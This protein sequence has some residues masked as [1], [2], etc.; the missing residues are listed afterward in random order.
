MPAGQASV[1]QL[2]ARQHGGDLVTAHRLGEEVIHAGRETARPF[3]GLHIGGH[4]HDQA[5]GA[6]VAP[7]QS[8]QASRHGEAIHPRHAQ[9]Q[10]HQHDIVVFRTPVQRRLT[11]LDHRHRIAETAQHGARH[12]TIDV[13]VIH[14]QHLLSTAERQRRVGVGLR[15]A[16]GGKR[17]RQLAPETG[18]FALAGVHA[19]T[20]SHQLHQ[21]AR[22]GQ[23]Q[24]GAAEAPRD[25]GIP[26]GEG[27]EQALGLHL[28]DADTGVIDLETD[29]PRRQ[30]MHHQ[31]DPAVP[32]E[33]EG[34]RQQVEQHLTQANGVSHD[35]AWQLGRAV[36]DEG[37]TGT[38]Q[39][40]QQ[41]IDDAIDGLLEI[42]GSPL[43]G[44]L[45]GLDLR[46]VQHVI[47]Q[48]HQHLPAVT[49]A[50]GIP[51]CA[52]V[53]RLG[54]QQLAHADDTVERRA[55]LMTHGGEEF[56]LGTAGLLGA[57]GFMLEGRGQA[58]Q[59]LAGLLPRTRLQP[60]LATDQQGRQYHQ[61][62]QQ[63]HPMHESIA[64]LA[65]LGG[66]LGKLGSHPQQQRLG[67]VT[68]LVAQRLQPRDR[69]G[70]RQLSALTPLCFL[71]PLPLIAPYAQSDVEVVDL[72]H[73]LIGQH[74]HRGQAHQMMTEV[75]APK[76]EGPAVEQLEILQH[77][78]PCRTTLHA[79]RLGIAREGVGEGDGLAVQLID[80]PDGIIASAVLELYLVVEDDT[81][82]SHGRQQ[83]GDDDGHA[84]PQRPTCPWRLG[85]SMHGVRVCLAA[86]HLIP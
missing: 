59:L 13:V 8:P 70:V 86:R 48:P 44:Q 1:L 35:P 57:F 49:Q 81:A 66:L 85:Q 4:R 5:G 73:H 56:G 42:K 76:D 55:N 80:R 27:L 82:H 84:D 9:I 67:D 24:S 29:S 16:H 20:P 32:G 68:D 19:Q 69:G 37:H 11:A 17:Q 52:V 46:E 51:V 39:L 63:Q 18:A 36:I 40:R 64:L 2:P 78:L 61:P 77:L 6:S 58:Q 30:R 47:H 26:L 15:L 25:R 72:A 41:Q 83:Q 12:F 14:H 33:L 65:F 75:A 53:Q 31:G 22:D 50:G 60:D 23:S 79:L 34:V 21:S 62:E 38:V 74:G 3:A 54:Q 45:A 71:P 10:Q 28:A 43:D 7:L